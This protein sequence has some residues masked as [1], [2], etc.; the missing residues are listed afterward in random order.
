MNL[1]EIFNIEKRG[2]GESRLSDSWYFFRRGTSKQDDSDPGSVDRS[3]CCRD[4]LC[5]LTMWTQ[6]YD[7]LS[8][9]ENEDTSLQ[10]IY[11][12]EMIC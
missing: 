8:T 7:V 1:K 3:S 2:S 11:R 10:S 12:W 9:I 4:C 6:N 5:P